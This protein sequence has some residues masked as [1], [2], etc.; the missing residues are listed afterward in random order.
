VAAAIRPF[1]ASNAALVQFLPA[2]IGAAFSLPANLNDTAH[3]P[4]M[5]SARRGDAI[6]IIAAD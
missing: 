2:T 3:A 6:A 1:A 5:Q 4:C